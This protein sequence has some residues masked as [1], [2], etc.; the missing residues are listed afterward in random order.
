MAKATT[1]KSRI[2]RN[3]A[4]P[5]FDLP[6][7]PKDGSGIARGR[8]VKGGQGQGKSGRRGGVKLGGRGRG[9]GEGAGRT[10]TTGDRKS[11]V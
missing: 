1:K 6:P 5:P 11:V 2:T 4:D 3:G 10:R 9:G 8:E 7:D